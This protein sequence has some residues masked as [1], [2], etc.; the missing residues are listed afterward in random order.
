MD[1]WAN[2]LFTDE[3][4]FRLNTDSCCRFIWKKPRTHSLPCNS[5]CESDFILMDDNAMLH[6]VLMVDEFLDSENICR[7]DWLVKSPD[8]NFTEHV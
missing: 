7:M 8:L 6:R 4:R 5:A 2:V 3:S 1:H